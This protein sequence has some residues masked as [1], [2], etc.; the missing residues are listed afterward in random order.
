MFPHVESM[1]KAWPFE[2]EVN[3]VKSQKRGKVLPDDKDYVQDKVIPD[4]IEELVFPSM[5]KGHR[6]DDMSTARQIERDLNETGITKPRFS[7]EV[8]QVTRSGLF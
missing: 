2:K 1:E 5:K 4:D 3:Q 8:W 6:L 7:L